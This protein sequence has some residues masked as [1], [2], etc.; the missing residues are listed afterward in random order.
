MPT[1]KYGLTPDYLPPLLFPSFQ[2]KK[3]RKKSQNLD[4]GK[5]L[6]ELKAKK[7]IP[8]KV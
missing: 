8:T 1:E 6:L 3:Q 4:E 2:P 7:I 5:G